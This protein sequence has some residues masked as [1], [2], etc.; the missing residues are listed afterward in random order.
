[1]NQSLQINYMNLYKACKVVN[2]VGAGTIE[3]LV[4]NEMNYYFRNEYTK[5][6][7]QLQMVFVLDLIKNQILAHAQIP[8][9]D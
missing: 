9:F 7:I 3:Y 8:P 1:M 6:S 4:D 5:L 2:Y